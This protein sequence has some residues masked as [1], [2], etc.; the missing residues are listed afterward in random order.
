L[1]K[2]PYFKH[3]LNGMGNISLDHNWELNGTDNRLSPPASYLQAKFNNVM[4]LCAMLPLLV[5][6]CLNS[7]L[8]QN[9]PQQVQILGSLVVIFLVF[10][11]TAILVKI[12]IEPQPFFIIT[13][14]KIVLINSF[15]A[16]LQA[17]L[18]GLAEL[19]PT[20]YTAPIMSGQDLA[21]TF[22]ALAMVCAIATSG[23]CSTP[24]PP[25]PRVARL[26]VDGRRRPSKNTL[27][28]AEQ[29]WG[30]VTKGAGK[31]LHPTPSCRPFPEGRDV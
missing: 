10:M 20:S 24:A 21:G 5:F 27:H 18:F 25:Q 19:L 16:I 11:I 12:P 30:H 2:S 15:G 14:A 3:K 22:G 29:D 23:A 31:D 17:S 26:Y 9:I 6:T 7:F 8:H 13:M 4:T 28:A 1:W